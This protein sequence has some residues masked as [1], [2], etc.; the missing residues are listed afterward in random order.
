MEKFCVYSKLTAKKEAQE[1]LIF[2][3]LSKRNAQAL[4]TCFCY[5]LGEGR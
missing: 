4:D 3:K 5:I 1:H 2:K